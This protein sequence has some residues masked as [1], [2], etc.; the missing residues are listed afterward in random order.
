MKY[1]KLIILIYYV[2]C[3]SSCDEDIA[4]TSNAVC[5]IDNCNGLSFS[6]GADAPTDCD[7]TKYELGDYCRQFINCE[8]LE[9]ECQYIENEDFNNCLDCVLACEEAAYEAG[10][11]YDIMYECESACRE[12]P[13]ENSDHCQPS[14]DGPYLTCGDYGADACTDTDFGYEC[15]QW[16]QC[17]MVDGVCTRVEDWRYRDCVYECHEGCIHL[18]QYS[19]YYGC[20]NNCLTAYELVDPFNPGNYSLG[21]FICEGECGSKHPH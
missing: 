18:T 19:Q 1:F 17:S 10:G 7:E 16:A 21:S 6:C 4:S 3:F 15:R 20:F 11:D 13:P 5:E 12:N 8:I 14:C 2:F 9:G